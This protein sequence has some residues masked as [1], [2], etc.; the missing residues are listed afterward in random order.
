MNRTIACSHLRACALL[1]LFASFAIPSSLHAQAVKDPAAISAINTALMSMGGQ[2]AFAAIQDAVVTAQIRGADGQPTTFTWKSIGMSLRA[3][4][5][6][7]TGLTISTA[8]GGTGYLEDV[9]GAVTSMDGRLAN[10]TFPHHLPGVALLFLLN[11]PDR[12]ISVISDNPDNP[13]LVH[14]RSV[15]VL[16]DQSTVTETQQ[17]WYIDLTTGLPV[18]MD[19][20]I[21]AQ[22]GED[23][24]GTVTF[25]SWQRSATVLVPQVLQDVQGTITV[26]V[27]QF[28]QG[29]STAIFTLP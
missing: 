16:S 4:V 26:G 21:P 27:P 28:N 19:Y 8:Q 18:R 9:S 5:A 17:D 13:N 6:A 14:V 10:S 23:T 22:S 20:V 29:L 15:Q 24:S 3:E 1:F 11:A 12:N 2:P 25:T 7:P